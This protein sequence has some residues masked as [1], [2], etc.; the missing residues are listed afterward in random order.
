MKNPE[1]LLKMSKKHQTLMMF[2]SVKDHLSKKEAEDTTKIWQS[3]LWNNH[4][5]AERYFYVFFCLFYF[6]FIICLFGG[7]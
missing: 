3:A 5:Q 2:V 1:E 6:Y 7:L 4:I